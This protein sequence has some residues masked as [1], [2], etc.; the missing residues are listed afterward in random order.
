MNEA[1]LAFAA[2]KSLNAK[3]W[4]V[5]PEFGV[6]S[7]EGFKHT[8]LGAFMWKDQEDIRALAVECKC[9]GTPRNS[10]FAALGQAVEYQLFFPEVL[11]VT[12]EGTFLSDQE[13]I[14]KKL[15]LGYMMINEKEE[16]LNIVEPSIESNSLFDRSLFEDQVRNRAILAL[17]FD[18]LFPG[19]FDK[20][21]FGGTERGELWIHNKPKGEIQ[22]R[23]WTKYGKESY[24]GIN[25]ESVHLIKNI[26][27]NV[28]IDE[29]AKLFSELPP[30]F[31]LDVA[32]RATILDTR[33]SRILDRQK[34]SIPIKG[35]IFERGELPACNLTKEQIRSE[36]V[37][38][39]DKL[40]YYTHIL[41]D[42]KVWEIESK[43]TKDNFLKEMT[44]TRQSLEK[45]YKTIEIWAQ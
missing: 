45:I 26:V 16:P 20:G 40:H 34:G 15:G 41:I 2:E 13:T 23:S 33:G 31:T 7:Y 39:S 27:N 38:R 42:R 1:K 6:L 21:F 35:S 9:Q 28:D 10:Y 32:E 19:S 43:L 30:E 5:I 3:K 37:E 44:R 36:I 17:T 18:Q 8:D 25:I 4:L 29:L 22:F 14:L 12:H 24:F 11:I